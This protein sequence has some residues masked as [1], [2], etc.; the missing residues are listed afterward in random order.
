MD[1]QYF[2]QALP[3]K[4]QDV[5]I[6]DF[7]KST[8]GSAANTALALSGCDVKTYFC[9]G[10]GDDEDGQTFLS[11]FQKGNVD[12]SLVQQTGK[13][14]FTVTMIERSGERTMMSYRGASANAMEVTP[15][16][17]RILKKVSLVLLSG[18]MLTEPSQAA[19]VMD[20]A[21]ELKQRGGTVALDPTPVVGS[22]DKAVLKKVFALTDVLLPNEDELST[23]TKMVGKV[24]VPCVAVKMGS[25]GAKMT[26]D[27]S[28]YIQTARE[29][30]AVDTT[31][32]GDAFNAGFIASM[33]SG[34]QPQMWLKKG[35][36]L[37]AAVVGKKGAV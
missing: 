37:A 24:S 7:R 14:G 13:T 17:G 34:D 29:V 35:V 12:T 15:E 31:G 25:R 27:V 20:V 16:V 36:D 32:A 22:V 30:E 23:I 10:V 21:Q 11:N 1:N 28:E 18:Y 6:V 8:G 4:G 2:V 26:F 33:V 3:I 9:G 5:K 19:F